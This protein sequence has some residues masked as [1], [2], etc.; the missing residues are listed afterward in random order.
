MKTKTTKVK[1]QQI[2]IRTLEDYNEKIKDVSIL[3]DSISIYTRVSTKG[4]IDNFSIKDQIQKGM[5]YI[6]SNNIDVKYIIIWREEG[7]SGDDFSVN[8][9]MT[10]V[11]SR[12]LLRQIMVLIDEGFV[13][14][15]WINDMSRLSRND[16][17]SNYLKLKFHS[18]SVLLVI[19]NN[20]YDFDN[21]NDKLM[22]G[23]FSVFNEYENNLRYSKS[24]SGKISKLKING[25]IG[26]KPNYGFQ[27]VHGRLVPH[28]NESTIIRQIF[29]WYGIEERSISYI[30][31]ELLRLNIQSPRGNTIWNSTSIRN[32]LHNE[33]YIG[34]Q[35]FEIRQLKGKS[36]K[37]CNEKGKLF[38]YTVQLEDKI[39]DEF[40]WKIVSDRHKIYLKQRMTETNQRTHQYLL[41]GLLY[42]SGCSEYLYGLQRPTKNK[43]LYFCNNKGKIWDKRTNKVC[44]NSRSVNLKILERLVWNSTVDVWSNSYQI[45]EQFKKDFLLPKINDRENFN[46]GLSNKLKSQSYMLSEL[47]TLENRKSQ[48]YSDYM[49]LRIKEK[50]YKKI[51]K[52]IDIEIGLRNKKIKNLTKEIEMLKREDNWFNWLDGFDNQFKDIKDWNSED[53]FDKMKDFL[54]NV[55]ER[56]DVIWD[57]ES[58]T[59]RIIIKYNMK[60]Y[61]DK[62][63][64]SGK[65][66][67]NIKKGKSERISNRFSSYRLSRKIGPENLGTSVS[68][69][70][71][72]DF[73]RFLG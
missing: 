54:N 69:S 55:I 49:M 2:V 19:D 71:V 20:I 44:T 15:L 62:R 3:K 47:S 63:I 11:L 72:T 59:H 13:D 35:D 61:K 67:F 17:V 30:Q 25:W 57:N 10:E 52:G 9:D 6:N 16:S 58:N 7:K 33:V 32:I 37:Y 43:Y 14:K 28:E 53:N 26:G 1:P 45:K 36:K 64:K 18:N 27:I 41:S 56:I 42:C 21:L 8:E 51:D 23:I 39:I 12:E 22:Y 29:K 5:K 34:K 60:I 65:W 73:A 31:N 50:D 4:Q 68:Y 40:T 46:Q 70:T 48:L 66:K 24:V 38:K